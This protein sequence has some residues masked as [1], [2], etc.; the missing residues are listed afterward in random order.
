MSFNALLRGLFLANT[1]HSSSQD[2]GK[3]FVILGMFIM[4]ILCFKWHQTIAVIKT[5]KHLYVN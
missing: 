2:G 1:E 4:Y 5:P 3:A